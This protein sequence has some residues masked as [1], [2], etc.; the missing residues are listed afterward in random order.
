MTPR[1]LSITPERL[2][3]VYEMLHAFAP[4]NRWSLP[5]AAEVRFVVSR[6]RGHQALWWVDGGRHHIEISARKHSHLASLVESMAHEMIHAKQRA[7][8]TETKGVEHNA[9]FRRLSAMVCRRFGFDE[10]QFFG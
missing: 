8:G 7:T 5:R 4:F 3:A 1:T 10:G 6:A 9:E 2:S